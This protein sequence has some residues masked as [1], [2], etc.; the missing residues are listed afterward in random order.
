MD[1]IQKQIETSAAR[2]AEL[3]TEQTNLPQALGVAVGNADAE[4]IIKL[5]RRAD[6][7]PIHIQSERIRVEQ[8]RIQAEEAK[9]PAM[10]AEIERLYPAVVETRQAKDEAGRAFS[11]ACNAHQ[12]AVEEVRQRRI[13]ISE[14]KRGVEALLNAK[15]SAPI[16][17]SLMMNGAR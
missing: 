1:D 13:D 5:R 14:R 6:D 11:L 15:P 16:R 4:E 9:F 10:H 7:L 8:L 12:S 2:L 17:Q 3:E